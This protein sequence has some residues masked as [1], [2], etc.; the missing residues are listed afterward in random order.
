MKTSHGLWAALTPLELASSPKIAEVLRPFL[1][2]ITDC[3]ECGVEVP[4]LPCRAQTTKATRVAALFMKRLLN[5]LR[6]TWNILLLGYTSQAGAVAAAAFENALVVSC[7]AGSIDR[8]EQ[9]LKSQT[10]LPWSIAALCRMDASQTTEDKD[11]WRVLYAQYQW[12]CKVKHPTLPSV[13]HDAFSVS[14]DGKAFILSV[15]ILRVKEAIDR[16]AV[17]RD[18]DTT[19]PRAVLWQERMDSIITNLDA[20]VDPITAKPLPFSYDGRISSKEE[21]QDEGP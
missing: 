11:Y 15:T 17:A 9:C 14:L 2:P 20:A 4:T 18:L 8:A 13:L 16:F 6:A 10:G 21:Q 3:Y 19:A 1:R 5:D 12:L 7:T